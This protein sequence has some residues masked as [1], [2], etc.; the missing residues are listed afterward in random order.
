VRANDWSDSSPAVDDCS[1]LKSETW[2][3]SAYDSISFVEV[4]QLENRF[5]N[6]EA[7]T[8]SESSLSAI[9]S[10]LLLAGRPSLRLELHLLSKQVRIRNPSSMIGW[11]GMAHKKEAA[12][13]DRHFRLVFLTVVT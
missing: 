12:I 7:G 13:N 5:R 9:P 3:I 8:L 6:E 1:V 11:T 4:I 2:T 10:S